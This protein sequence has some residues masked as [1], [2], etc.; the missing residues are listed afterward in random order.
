MKNHRNQNSVMSFY[1]KLSVICSW[2]QGGYKQDIAIFQ[3][4]QYVWTV[5]ESVRFWYCWWFCLILSFIYL[6]Y[7]YS[8]FLHVLIRIH[9][10]IQYTSLNYFGNSQ[11]LQKDRQ[12]LMMCYKGVLESVAQITYAYPELASTG[13][14]T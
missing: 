6:W 2:L 7:I 13:C 4:D 9:L 5:K 8:N 14:S 3:T 12:R 10:S 11:S 1:Q